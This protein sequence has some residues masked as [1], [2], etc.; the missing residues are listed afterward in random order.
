[1]LDLVLNKR[2]LSVKLSVKATISVLLVVMAVGLPQIAHA[3][4]GVKA[5][6]VWMPM[7]MPALLAGIL[8]GWQWGLG[9]GILSPVISYG[10]TTLAL[11]SV[12]PNLQRLPYMIL[13]IG[14]YGLISGL[15][16][17]Q[18]QK[19]PALAFPVVIGAQLSGRAIYL[20]Y[21]LIAGK[22]FAY[23]WSS[24]QTSLVGLYAQAILVPAIAI[25]LCMVLKHEQKSE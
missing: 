21:N 13:E 19:T 18:V 2:K 1:M 17:K 9:V 20:I 10:F 12:M 15:F 23:L 6:S 7:Y 5:G 11:G 24:I 8:L 16:S 22:S 3:V 25:V 4:G 14:A